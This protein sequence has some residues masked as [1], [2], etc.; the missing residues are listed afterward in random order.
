VYGTSPAPEHAYLQ[1]LQPV[2][3]LGLLALLR[4]SPVLELELEVDIG[5][6]R[7]TEQRRRRVE[8]R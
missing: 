7:H 6:G 2:F 1:L 8:L 5:P 3:T 4:L